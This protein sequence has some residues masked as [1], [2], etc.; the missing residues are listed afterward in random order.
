MVSTY[1]FE[2]YPALA[3]VVSQGIGLHE[4]RSLG[5]WSFWGSALMCV[6]IIFMCLSGPLMWWRRRPRGSARLGAPRGR[7]PIRGTPV[8]AVGLVALGVFLPLFGLSLLVVL[9]LDQLVLRRVPALSD[10][11]STS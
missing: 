6:A 5:L 1:G 10:W 2:D 7:M 8:L 3:K 11:F 4:G 9:L